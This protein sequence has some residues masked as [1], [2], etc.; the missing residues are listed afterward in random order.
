MMKEFLQVL[1]L[2]ERNNSKQEEKI[3]KQEEKISKQDEEISKLKDLVSQLSKKRSLIILTEDK[4][5]AFYGGLTIPEMK[6][7]KDQ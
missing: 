5:E 7:K 3:S 1:K 2:Q 4:Q 6:V